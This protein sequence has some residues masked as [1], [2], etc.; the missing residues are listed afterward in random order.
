MTVLMRRADLWSGLMFL[1]LAGAILWVGTDYSLGRAGRIGPGYAP[2]LLAYALGGL[3]LFLAVRAVGGHEDVEARI[4]WRPVLLI[5]ASILVFAAMLAW[6]GLV[7]AILASVAVA[8]FAQGD[9]GLA[10]AL[11]LGLVLAL[12]S[13]LL[14]VQGLG[15]PIPVFTQ[16]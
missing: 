2:R 15:L 9:N 14:F 12:F 3:G 5:L 10:T 4:A 1:A 16:P 11:W 13:W 7:P 6:F 8:A